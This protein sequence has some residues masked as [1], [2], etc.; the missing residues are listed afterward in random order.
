MKK[1]ILF[2]TFASFIFC[3]HAFAFDRL[4]CESNLKGWVVSTSESANSVLMS[5]AK[6][7]KTMTED[8]SIKM[9]VLDS[10]GE[11]IATIFPWNSLYVKVPD[12]V[13]SKYTVNTLETSNG[14]SI[15]MSALSPE[16][17]LRSLKCR[18]TF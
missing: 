3:S 6:K 5:E 9:N 8:Q 10:S 11:V 15:D 13:R 14:F 16:K 17:I 7:S 4:Q 18:F 1:I 2:S 12:H